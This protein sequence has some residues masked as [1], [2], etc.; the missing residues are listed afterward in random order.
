MDVSVIIVNYNSGDFLYNCIRSIQENIKLVDLEIIVVDN[1]SSDDSIKR[2]ENLHKD[3]LLFVQAGENLGFSKA[4]NLGAKLARGKIL[5]FL[6]PDTQLD[7][8]M[9]DDYEKILKDREKGFFA[10]YVNPLKNRDGSVRYERN[11]QLTPE[12]YLAYLLKLSTVKWYYLGATV[13]VSRE[14]YDKVGG[15]N[16]EIFMYSDDADFFYKLD[17]MSILVVEMP[18]VIFHYGGAS[19]E[20]VWS[21][22]DKEIVIQKSLRVFYHSNHLGSY[23]Y[24]C[25]QAMLILSF[26][27]KFKRMW[28]QVKAIWLSKYGK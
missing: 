5:H 24:W 4:N 13:I 21:N 6:N 17:K 27:P 16:E 3:R 14:I 10:V 28:W 25:L 15:W 19:S 9:S 22:M 11:W 26:F 8:K 2:C 23:R 7:E 18:A 1:A 20:K 12:N